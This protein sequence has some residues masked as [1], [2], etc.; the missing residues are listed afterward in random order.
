MTKPEDIPQWAWEKGDE[1]Y[2][3]ALSAKGGPAYIAR[4][5]LSA[6]EREREACA[7]LAEVERR[8]D[9]A[10]KHGYK[11]TWLAVSHEIASAIR[12]RKES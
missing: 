5:I 9:L 8:T 10:I 12:N 3:N 7:K 11:P 4:A 1:I 6:V 2:L